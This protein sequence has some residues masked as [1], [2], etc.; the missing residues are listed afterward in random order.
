VTVLV[1]VPAEEVHAGDRIF[2]SRRIG[3]RRVDDILEYDTLG[4]EQVDCFVIVYDAPGAGQ[5][6]NKP[7]G[8]QGHIGFYR[9]DV[10]GTIPYRRGELVQLERLHLVE[11]S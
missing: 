9:R 10:V 2:V 3:V 8:S 1:E 7:S 11:R 5:G 6:W 4:M